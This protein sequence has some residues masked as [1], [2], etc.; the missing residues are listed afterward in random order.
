MEK[1][2]GNEP[3][4]S[5]RHGEDHTLL[6]KGGYVRNGS[7]SDFSAGSVAVPLYWQTGRC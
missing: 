1:A 2:D 7:I 3:L 6:G 4:L 5:V